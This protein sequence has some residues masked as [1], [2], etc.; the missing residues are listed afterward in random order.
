[1]NTWK[2]LIK[3]LREILL[4]KFAQLLQS[5]L[6]SSCSFWFYAFFSSCLSK[7]ERNKFTFLCLLQHT[8]L[9]PS[10]IFSVLLFWELCLERNRWSFAMWE[11]RCW[12]LGY[13]SISS[14]FQYSCLCYFCDYSPIFHQI[15]DLDCNFIE[16]GG[17]FHLPFQYFFLH[18][19]GSQWF[20]IM[21]KTSQYFLIS[22][23]K[24]CI[25]ILRGRGDSKLSQKEVTWFLVDYDF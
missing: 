3:N 22:R 17:S 2:L 24:I 14:F 12:N 18:K 6:F 20:L 16:I 1:M 5:E 11:I 21:S 25:C 19:I 7:N 13:L 23:G 4:Q 10:L 9:S 15:Q 8:L